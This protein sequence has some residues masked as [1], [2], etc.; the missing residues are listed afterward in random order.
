MMKCPECHNMLVADQNS[1]GAVWH[2]Y[3]CARSAVN[4]AVLRKRLD[5]E[6]VRVIWHQSEAAQLSS[7]H[8]PSC[9]Q[10]LRAFSGVIHEHGIMLEVCRRCQVVCF[11][12]DELSLL[13]QDVTEDT[14][15]LEAGKARAQC[16][17][18]LD[19]YCQAQARP[20][21]ITPLAVECLWVI[22][23]VLGGL[24]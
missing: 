6:I 20:N 15:S 4:L 9:S 23:D 2:C 5:P 22:L 16:R 19:R 13:R 11:S 18:E 12:N 14:L 3:D 7:R 10:L 1:K 21:D 8:C 17:I 24:V